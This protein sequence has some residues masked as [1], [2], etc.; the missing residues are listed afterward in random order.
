MASAVIL[1][2]V[3]TPISIPGA[4]TPNGDG[5]ND[6][7]Y[8]LGGPVNSQVEEFAV[9]N[10]GG[11][12]VFH[13]HHVAPGDPTFAWNGSFHGSPAPT[14]TYVYFVVMQFANGSRQVYKGTV[15][16]VR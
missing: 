1:V 13:V 14:G 11:A 6:L 15:V 4:F 5:H 9:F 7:F 8:V 16:L 3:Y 12:E 10:R 2:N